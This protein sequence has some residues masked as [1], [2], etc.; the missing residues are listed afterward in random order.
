[1][2]RASRSSLEAEADHTETAKDKYPVSPLTENQ[3]RAKYFKITQL[4][5]T[6]IPEL[7]SKVYYFQS[8]LLL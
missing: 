6:D 8:N 3:G 2:W 7:T 4:Q 1:M 5:T